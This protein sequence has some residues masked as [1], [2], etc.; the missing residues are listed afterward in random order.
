MELLGQAIGTIRSCYRN[1]DGRLVQQSQLLAAGCK[2]ACLQSTEASL[3]VVSCS[4]VEINHPTTGL[5][6]A[7]LLLWEARS[8]PQAYQGC[9][10]IQAL[11]FPC[12]LPCVCFLV[13]TSP[14]LLPRVYFPCLLR[15]VY[16]LVSA[17]RFFIDTSVGEF[18]RWTFRYTDVLCMWR[19]VPLAPFVDIIKALSKML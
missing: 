13:S 10:L 15:R 12:L 4:G 9:F 16:F 17:S 11:Y 6:V 5:V 1:M 19:E 3:A 8:C 18:V 14:C 7:V 2:R